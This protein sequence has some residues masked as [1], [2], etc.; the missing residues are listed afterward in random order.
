MYRTALRNVL[1]HKG[2]LLMTMLA[3]LLGTAFVAGT[4][5]FSDSVGQAFKNSQSASFDNISVQV[6]NSAAGSETK[7]SDNNSSALPLTDATVKRIAAL[8]GTQSARGTVTG[9]AGLSDP[10]GNLIGGRGNTQGSNWVAGPD[11]RDSSYPMVQGAGPTDSHQIAVDQ[12]TAQK[13]GFKVGDTVRLAVDGPV[14]QMT[15]TGIFTTVDPQVKAGGSLVLFDTA[16]AQHFYLK[17]GQFT[18]IQ[19]VA[20]PGTSQ[21]QL[22]DQV[23][24]VIPHSGNIT[25]KTGVQLSADSLAQVEAATSGMRTAL[26][27]FAGIALFVGIFL[28]SNTFTMLIAQRTRELALMR[29]IGASRRQITNSVLLEAL[30][31]GVF[32]SL[33]GLLAGIGIGAGLKALFGSGGDLPSGGLVLSATTVVATLVTGVVVTVVAALLPSIRASRVAPVAA[34][35]S[36]DQPATQK[37]LVVR[38][39]IGAAFFGTGL[40][41]VLYGAHLGGSD[42]RLPVGAGAGLILIGAFVLTPLLSRP[43]IALVGPL[44]ARLYGVSGKLAK[45]NALR[46]P[47]R[48]AA[49]ASALTIGLTLISALTVIGASVT[50]AVTKEVTSGMTADYAISMTLGDPISPT[51]LP[52]I[53]GTAGV[54]AASVLDAQ[55][56]KA[57]GRELSVSGFDAA[58]FSQLAAPAMVGGSADAIRQGALLVSEDTAASHH[59][60]VG[61]STRFTYPD[62]STGTVRIGGIYKKN[63]LF[64]PVMMGESV[65]APHTTAPYYQTVLVKGAGGATPALEQALKDSTGRNP[66]VDVQSQKQ[67]VKDFSSQIS[68]LLNVMYGL[69]GMAV[70]IA[71]LGVVN[72]LAMSV[73]ERKREIG[74]LRAIGLERRGVKRMVRLESVVIAAFGAVLGVAIGG[75]LA[76]AAVQLL[77]SSLAGLTTSFPVGQLAAYV[78]AAALVGLGAALWPARRAARLD[79]LDSIKTD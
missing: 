2:R 66:L 38:N 1:A 58:S 57:D 19:A 68:L 29:A 79:I 59:W 21:Q 13:N 22:L 14:E 51:L 74:M 42:G 15:V 67:M 54:T 23:L 12:R 73:F 64:G 16:T 10:Q 63:D 71:V 56:V 30:F 70:L 32:A 18:T 20:R 69:L 39:S 11:G 33:G 34:M 8:P 76:W 61:G 17:P 62:G 40:A 37:S 27:A 47:R 75:F 26:L 36:N 6:H 65:L 5:V 24:P 31:V 78:L 52:G 35:R 43:L 28:I 49:T 7:A 77:K 53:K 9:F 72:T 60:T 55:Y 41:A 45:Q 4:M 46:N 3:V 25:A 48:T 44:F 50:D